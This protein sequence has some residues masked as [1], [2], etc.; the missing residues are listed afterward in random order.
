MELLERGEIERIDRTE[1]HDDLHVQMKLL[2]CQTTSGYVYRWMTFV[3][4]V[5][6]VVLES[7]RASNDTIWGEREG[8]REGV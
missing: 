1:K 2:W 6:L 8:E 3:E 7:W 5:N 4:Y